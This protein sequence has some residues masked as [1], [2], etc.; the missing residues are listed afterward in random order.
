MRVCMTYRHCK[1]CNTASRQSLVLSQFLL[2]VRANSKAKSVG[3]VDA[4]Y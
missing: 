1:R 4:F 3:Y 2:G